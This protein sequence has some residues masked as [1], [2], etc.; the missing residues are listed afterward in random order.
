MLAFKHRTR[1]HRR[2]VP[3]RSKS[4][5]LAAAAGAVLIAA[6]PFRAS[7]SPADEPMSGTLGEAVPAVAVS[8]GDLNVASERGARILLERIRLAAGAVCPQ[9]SDPRDLSHVAMR[10]RCV[11]E[12]IARAVEQVGSPRLAAVYSAS[13]RQS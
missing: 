2:A 10:N 1:I 4:L 5:L 7:A 3:S 11:R 9:V 8:Y 6:A 13:A 12:A